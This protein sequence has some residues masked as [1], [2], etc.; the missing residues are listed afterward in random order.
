MPVV[1]H[2]AATTPHSILAAPRQLVTSDTAVL[3][4]DSFMAKRASRRWISILIALGMPI[5]V[6]QSNM[7]IASGLYWH[8]P[9]AAREPYSNFKYLPIKD[10]RVDHCWVVTGQCVLSYG[11]VNLSTQR[12]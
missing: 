2:A 5:C 3:I 7:R 11:I 12:G 8:L 9:A 6:T 1:N 4:R 10:A